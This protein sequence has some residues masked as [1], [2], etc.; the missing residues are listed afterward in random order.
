[1]YT[2][3]LLPRN[4]LAAYVSRTFMETSRYPVV[5]VALNI[6]SQEGRNMKIIL[7]S[8]P[9]SESGMSI[10]VSLL[11]GSALCG[12]DGVELAK[13]LVIATSRNDTGLFS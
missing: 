8:A 7:L 6:R 5:E 11:R 4:P 10:W 13:G 12:C 3:T 2:L 9:P 1:M